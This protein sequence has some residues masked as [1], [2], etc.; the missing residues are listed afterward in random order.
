MKSIKPDYA[1]QQRRVSDPPVALWLPPTK[2]EAF[3]AIADTN[4]HYWYEGTVHNVPIPNR[5]HIKPYRTSSIFWSHERQ[6]FLQIPCDCTEIDE[7]EAMGG[8]NQDVPVTW[9]RIS[10][11]NEIRGNRCLS[12]IGYGHEMNSLGAR[13]SPS[14]MPELL[15]DVYQY[16]G[17]QQK[18]TCQLAGDLSVL[19]GLAAFSITPQSSIQQVGA[20]LKWTALGTEWAERGQIGQGS[21][22]KL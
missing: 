20:L 14:W 21:E 11:H 3:T 9:S 17:A 15:P 22:A 18:E 4:W 7:E 19:L 5:E 10:F 2:R 1:V 6:A 8:H 16:Q 12:L 13:G